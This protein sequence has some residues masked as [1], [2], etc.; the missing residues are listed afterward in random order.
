MKLHIGW[1]FSYLFILLVLF[2][3]EMFAIGR[4]SQ[5]ALTN[6]TTSLVREAP[7]VAVPIMLF[8]VWLAVH[9]GIRLVPIL[10][11]REPM[12]WI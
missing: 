9:F 1:A 2:G 8:L 11:G 7:W 6:V 3:F 5:Y 10:F 4:N 12:T